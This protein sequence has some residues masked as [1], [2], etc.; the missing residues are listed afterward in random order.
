MEAPDVC[1]SILIDTFCGAS[2]Y[3]FIL[4][5]QGVEALTSKIEDLMDGSTFSLYSFTPPGRGQNN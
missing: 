5:H 3:T 2:H 1:I 4:Y